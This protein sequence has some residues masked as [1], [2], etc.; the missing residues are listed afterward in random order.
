MCVNLNE[1]EL[2]AWPSVVGRYS[3]VDVCSCIESQTD[4]PSLHETRSLDGDDLYTVQVGIDNTDPL[5]VKLNDLTRKGKLPKERILYRYLND[6]VEIMYN[7]FKTIT[8]LGGRRTANFIRG[9][10]NLGDGRHSHLNQER[11][12]KINLGGPSQSRRSPKQDTP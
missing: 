11:D 9:P 5:C 4:S 6:V 3:D 1:Y 7:P 2:L 8:Y 12:K 10:M